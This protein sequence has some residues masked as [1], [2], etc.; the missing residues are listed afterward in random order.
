MER[1]SSGTT[2][3]RKR[4]DNNKILTESSCEAL[5]GAGWS[6]EPWCCLLTWR[7]L[8]KK[9]TC[10][11]L[12]SV[13]HECALSAT[14]G[15]W[16]HY[17]NGCTWGT[18]EEEAELKLQYCFQKAH[19]KGKQHRGRQAPGYGRSS[20]SLFSNSAEESRRNTIQELTSW[21]DLTNWQVNASIKEAFGDYNDAERTK[22]DMVQQNAALY[23]WKPILLQVQTK[24]WSRSIWWGLQVVTS[25]IK[26][27]P[28]TL[29][30]TKEEYSA[31]KSSVTLYNCFF[32]CYT[33]QQQM[34][35]ATA[36]IL[37]TAT[38]T[39]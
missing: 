39:D 9:N 27:I 36:K 11:R 30:H 10:G 26:L 28:S 31:K 24:N 25:I 12:R 20:F 16:R 17:H 5:L 13:S 14:R 7:P 29:T 21:A 1:G 32:S 4:T 19:T 3:Q 33:K 37:K 2:Q 23:L 35:T 6:C 18:H 38:E 34:M 8:G 15:S 22:E